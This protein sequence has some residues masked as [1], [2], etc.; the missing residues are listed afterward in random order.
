MQ[1]L[2]MYSNEFSGHLNNGLAPEQFKYRILVEGDSWMD[3]SAMVH[4]SLL[5]SLA[6]EMDAGGEAVLFINLAIFGDTMRRMG[7]NKR[8]FVQWV[9]TAFGWKFDA[10]LLSAGGNDFIDAARDEKPGEGLLKNLAVQAP[11]A[12]GRDCLRPEGVSDLVKKWLDPNFSVLY[13]AVQAS[14]HRDVPIF[15]NSYDTP[16]ARNAPAFQN[17]RPWL[18]TSYVKNSIPPALW[19]DLTEALFGEV[20]A[21]VGGWAT[22]RPNVHIV[23]TNGTLIP[24]TPG[25]TGNDHDWQ[26]EIHPNKGGWEKLAKVW[27]T[28]LKTVLVP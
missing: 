3:R 27:R 10:I 7:Q 9:R 24:A 26:N 15:L 6:P 2:V 4:T 23:P 21:A 14:R 22:G 20:Q 8:D 5:Q 16:T 17:G 12:Q 28:S 13:D 19:P 25:T 11:P 1:S 18:Y